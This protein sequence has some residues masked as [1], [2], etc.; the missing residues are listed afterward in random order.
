MMS[1]S[2][3]WLVSALILFVGTVSAVIARQSRP[4]SPPWWKDERIVNE[5]QLKEKQIGK[6][7]T[8]WN[9]TAP[10]L[11]E[12]SKVLDSQEQALLRVIKEGRAS[13]AKVKVLIEQV[14]SM[15]ARRSTARQFMLYKMRMVMTPDQRV[16]FDTIHAK[17]SRD[18]QRQPPPRSQSSTASPGT[19]SSPTSQG[20]QGSPGSGARNPEARPATPARP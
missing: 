7:D 20:S 10:E 4:P 13:E 8:I 11:F 5:L 15:R 3:R 14:E 12:Q 9:E 17:W 1:P 6:I 16:K 18:N 2:K 19:Q